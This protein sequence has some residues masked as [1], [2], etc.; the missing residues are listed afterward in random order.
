LPAEVDLAINALV[1]ASLMKSEVD[2]TKLTVTPEGR[3]L[4]SILRAQVARYIGGAYGSVP[5]EDLGTTA[6]VLTSITAGLS[7]MSACG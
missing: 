7:D 3:E 6:R 5:A 4:V 2:E 1:E